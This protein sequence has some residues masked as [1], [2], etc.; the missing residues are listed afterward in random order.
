MGL[1]PSNSHLTSNL[2]VSHKGNYF[3]I[4]FLAGGDT[5]TRAS[6]RASVCVGGAGPRCVH[7]TM[8]AVEFALMFH[9]RRIRSGNALLGSARLGGRLAMAN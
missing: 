1:Q 2:L 8:A 7:E 4:Q 6:G 9:G 3:S 5:A